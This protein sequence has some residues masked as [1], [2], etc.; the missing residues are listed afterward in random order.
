[1]AKF[2]RNP[3][4][5]A[6]AAKQAFKCASAA[7]LNPPRELEPTYAVDCIKIAESHLR[8]LRRIAERQAN[9]KA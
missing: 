7:L 8:N 6:H 3:I 4:V 5:A 1:M 9:V 2:S